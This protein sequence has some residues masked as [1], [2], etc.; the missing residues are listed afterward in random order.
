MLNLK[1]L[2]TTTPNNSK[3]NN[4]FNLVA[5]EYDE[6]DRIEQAVVERKKRHKAK[7]FYNTTRR[8]TMF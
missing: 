7:M 2:K 4:Y 1:Q 6:E 5:T 8:D 3:F